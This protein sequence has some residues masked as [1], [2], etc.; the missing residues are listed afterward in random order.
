MRHNAERGKGQL[1]DEQ[2]T[3]EVE[4]SKKVNKNRKE[5][6]SGQIEKKRASRRPEVACPTCIGLDEMAVLI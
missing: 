2:T 1:Q 4:M 6:K 3:D 5:K